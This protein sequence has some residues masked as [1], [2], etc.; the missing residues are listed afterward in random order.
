MVE[1]LKQAIEKKGSSINDYKDVEGRKGGFQNHHCV[2][3]RTGR[4]CFT[5][6]SEIVRGI[7]AGRGTHYCP[8]CQPL[9]TEKRK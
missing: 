9:S 1:V 8:V 2:Y 6:G 5:C 4:P 7:V 3:R